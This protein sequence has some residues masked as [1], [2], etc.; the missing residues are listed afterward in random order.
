MP[1]AQT[2]QSA[3]AESTANQ[4]SDEPVRTYIP[5]PEPVVITNT[6]DVSPVNSAMARADAAEKLAMETLSM[7]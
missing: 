1:Q 2:A 7:R 6:T 4:N 5:S 3:A